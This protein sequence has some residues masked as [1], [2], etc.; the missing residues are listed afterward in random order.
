[1]D[2]YE[3]GILSIG[4]LGLAECPWGSEATVLS[5]IE[6]IVEGKEGERFFGVEVSVQPGRWGRG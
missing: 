6:R 2:C 1:M 3:K 4:E 5:I